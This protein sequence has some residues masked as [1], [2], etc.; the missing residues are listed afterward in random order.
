M[1]DDEVSG[2]RGHDGPQEAQVVGHSSCGL[3]RMEVEEMNREVNHI[4]PEMGRG[5]EGRKEGER[6]EGEGEAALQSPM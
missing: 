2:H 1:K 5:G 4:T 3:Q 6:G